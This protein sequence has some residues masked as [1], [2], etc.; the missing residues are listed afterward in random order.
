VARVKTS[1]LVSE[2]SGSI[3]GATY[4][5]DKAGQ[6]LSDRRGPTKSQT[7]K[8]QTQRDRMMRTSSLWS[9]LSKPVRQFW[10]NLAAANG[11]P[12]KAAF[13]RTR[14]WEALSST[15]GEWPHVGV[16][17][18]SLAWLSCC[19]S[20]A[21]GAVC[22]VSGNGTK[23]VALSGDCQHWETHTAAEQ[24]NW[25]SVC[26][27]E[28]LFMFCAVAATGTHRVMTSPDGE[29]WTARTASAENTWESVVWSPDLHL[30]CAVADTGS[31][32][33]MTS[34]DGI[35][36]TARAAANA[37]GW[38][39]IT[40]SPELG[41]F[42]ATAW[43]GTHRIM[44]SPDG[45]NWTARA[46]P[47]ADA[48]RGICWSP[49]LG[50]FCAVSNSGALRIKTSP[51]GINWTAHEAPSAEYWINVTW[52]K[53]LNLFC[54]VASTGTHTIATSADGAYWR[55]ETTQAGT[56][57]RSIT[58][59]PYHAMFCAPCYGTAC[60]AAISPITIQPTKPD[61]TPLL[62]DYDISFYT[63]VP[64]VPLLTLSFPNVDS[65]VW[66][67]GGSPPAQTI[68][69]TIPA[70]TQI[71]TPDIWAQN[72]DGASEVFTAI[73]FGHPVNPGQN[74]YRGRWKLAEVI[75]TCRGPW[76][77]TAM[78][79]PWARPIQAGARIPIRCQNLSRGMRISPLHETIIT[80]T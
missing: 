70:P 68:T 18:G 57:A 54:A 21:L 46:T 48:W 8:A 28:E 30:F 49:E 2:I 78:A 72:P 11:I 4:R 69:A 42:C 56:L 9:G 80:L 3:G 19:F 59:S 79:W 76:T 65:W 51:D 35:N 67:L 7:A 41:L 23:R 16:N 24:N 12:A 39:Y 36:W 75:H 37:S 6:V 43:T 40:W 27:S 50:L 1:S 45:I 60:M 62:T 55:S 15:L 44:T 33:V 5:R 32:L 31:D 47:D 73:W 61:E 34:P 53:Q 13:W 10:R 20:P 29:N 22:A 64:A 38:L 77:T 66:T 58:W 63:G 26:W 14:N 25:R 74:T 17:E 52:S 71:R